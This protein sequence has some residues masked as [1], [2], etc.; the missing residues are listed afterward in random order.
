MIRVTALCLGQSSANS[1]D[2]SRRVKS[3][4]P[5][6]LLRTPKIQLRKKMRLSAALSSIDVVS[7]EA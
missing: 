3:E 6:V 4:V 7:M 2:Y 1:D 5:T